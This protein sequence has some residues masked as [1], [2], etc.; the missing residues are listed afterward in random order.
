M[1]KI[2]LVDGNSV[3]FRAYYASSYGRR[4]IT[5][6]N[7]ETNAVYTFATMF[8]KAIEVL[9]PTHVLVAFDS[10]VKG[11]RNEWFPEYKGTRK[12][13]DQSLVSQFPIA[14]ELLQ[15]ANI[16]QY[17][18]D[19]IEADDIIGALSK[20]FSHEEVIIL[21]SDRDLLQLISANVN[22]CLM[23]QGMSEIEIVDEKLLQEKY[24]ITPKQVIEL[25]SLMGDSSDNI[26]GVKG[27][28][29]KT[30]LKL[31]SS[32]ETLDGVYQHIDEITGSLKEKL[33]SEKDT[34]YLSHRLA[35]IITDLP[36]DL[37]I[38]DLNYQ[39]DN[40]NL[41]NFYVKYEMASLAKKLEVTSNDEDFNYK[42]VKELANI[43]NSKYSVVFDYDNEENT[44]YGV[45][46]SDASDSFY[47]PCSDVKEIR[48]FFSKNTKLI[49]YNYKDYCHQLAL[50]EDALYVDDLMISSF[51]VDSQI[52]SLD[53][54]LAKHQYNLNQTNSTL[55]GTKARKNLA[56][57]EVRA[58]Y[59]CNLARI[60]YDLYPVY[61]KRLIED[62]MLDLYE[63]IERPLAF[64]L[65]RMEK[66]GVK[67]DQ[68][69]LQT[70]ASENQEQITKLS[71]E[72]IKH[73]G[74]DF[75]INSPKQI[76]EV[77]FDDLKLPSNKKRSTGQEELEKLQFLHPI[78]N[79]LLDYRKYQKIYSTYSDGLQKYI[80]NDGKIHTS[81]QQCLTQTGRLSSTDPNLQ[82]IGVRNEDVK[83]IRKAFVPEFDYLLS[84]D[85]SQIE[86]R[87]LA[88]LA[89][90]ENMIDYFKNDYDI[91]SAT[92]SAIYHY[93]INELT[94]QMRRNAKAVNFGIVYGISD[95]GLA[96]QLGI[97]RKQAQ[98]FIDAYFR[99]FPRIQAYMEEVVSSCQKL[100]YV[101][102]ICKHK[103]MIPEINDKNYMMREFGK[104]AAMNAPIQGSAADLI[105][106]AMI[107][108]DKKIKEKK[109]VSKMIMSV[110]DELL[111]DVVESE[112]GELTT[113]VRTEMENAMELSVPLKVEISYAKDWYGAK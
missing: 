58:Q 53:K 52:N 8:F 108:L 11:V 82:N 15:M 37:T 59:Y 90:D 9:K 76:A 99:A 100:G 86:L 88:H 46:F 20:R 12:E 79:L 41:Y 98:D 13:I 31:L 110:H 56:T 38:E 113:L 49:V 19:G 92:A 107:N 111:F 14:R 109:F 34:A 104:R 68:D 23:K 18:A 43:N 16:K 28:G 112:L 57:L 101:Q 74:R 62:D 78:I 6:F 83:E 48:E 55:Y 5:S 103:R 95:F 93:E 64:V 2:L 91:H 84:A 51:L 73:A 72:I 89:Q 42:V 4:M 60:I 63:N 61:Q 81:Y 54:L 24:F 75:N 65:Y 70:I 7:V 25:K 50:D 40:N 33:I 47:F 32:Y 97:T 45:A 29:E 69:I 85:Y 71:D 1:N 27:V 39:L 67:V 26:P 96:N 44:L 21:T 105:K 102:T 22:V 35:T 10:G 36:I 94:P 3:L 77:L 66:Y 30:A 80:Q 87:I 106:I 17:Q